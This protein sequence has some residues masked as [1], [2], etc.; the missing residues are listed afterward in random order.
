MCQAKGSQQRVMLVM[1]PRQYGS[2]QELICQHSLWRLKKW[3]KAMQGRQT[4][5][6][7]CLSR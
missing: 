6:L 7:Q 3:L 2:R 1:V 5:P 4:S